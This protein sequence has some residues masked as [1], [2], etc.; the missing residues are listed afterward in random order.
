[1]KQ[2][3]IISGVTG[4]TGNELA[5]KL[6]HEG[7]TVIGFD[8]FFASSIKTVEDLLEEERFVFY[9]YDLN[10][11]EQMEA[12]KGK[13][14]EEKKGFEGLVYINCAAVVHTEHFYYVNR[15]FET[16]VLGMKRFLEQAIEVKAD[17]Y[18]NCSTSEVYSMASWEETGVSESDYIVMAN[19]EHSQRTSYATGKLLT[20]FFMKDAVEEKRSGAV[21]SGLPMCTAGMSY[22]PSISYP[23]S[24]RNWVRREVWSYWKIGKNRRTFT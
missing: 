15:T 2:L 21:L 3:Y 9:E 19:A 23:I 12:L 16:N 17:I 24:S 8:N 18:I 4:M 10:N 22:I 5:R 14:L 20:E 1:M 11:V 13:V 6:V 7:G